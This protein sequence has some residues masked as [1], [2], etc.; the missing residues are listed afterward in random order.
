[1]TRINSNIPVQS[2]TDEHLLAE[3][4]EIKRLPY[5]LKKAI[6]SGSIYHIPDRFTLGRGHILFFV[7]KQKFLKNRYIELYNECITRGFNVMDYSDNWNDI[8]IEYCDDY[9]ATEDDIQ[10]IR[11]RISFRIMNSNKKNWHHK[12][13]KINKQQAIQLLHY[14]NF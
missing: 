1:M 8:P 13:I 10:M 7:N 6:R 3:H 9:Q 11:D 14:G 4:R 5:C 2:L 12:N